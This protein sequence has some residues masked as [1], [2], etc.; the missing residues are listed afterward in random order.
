MI[1]LGEPCM[2]GPRVRRR[3]SYQEEKEGASNSQ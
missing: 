1:L 3:A 2:G